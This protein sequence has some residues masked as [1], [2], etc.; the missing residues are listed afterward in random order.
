MCGDNAY[1]RGLCYA[2]YQA[3][4]AKVIKS[5]KATWAELEANGKS[6]PPFRRTRAAVVALALDWKKDETE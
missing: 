4:I 5:G 3:M 6:L 1:A 2:H